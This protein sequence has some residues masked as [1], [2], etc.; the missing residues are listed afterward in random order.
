MDWESRRVVGRL[1]AEVA[2]ARSLT[3]GPGDSDDSGVPTLPGAGTH[4][5]GVQLGPT[6]PRGAA[7][8]GASAGVRLLGQARAVGLQVIRRRPGPAGKANLT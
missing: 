8:P 2:A 1:S 7:R 4:G 3:T 6:Q 5:P